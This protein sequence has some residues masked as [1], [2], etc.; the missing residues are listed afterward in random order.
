MLNTQKIRTDFPILNQTDKPLV[1]FDNA[2]MT[3]RPIQVIEEI[4]KY[5]TEYPAC[6]GRS[7]HKL[8]L[9]VGRKITEGRQKV[10]KFINAKS[11]KEIIFTKNTT[12][13][14]NLVAN[15]I[16]LKTG[17][18]VLGSH[19]EHNS[20]LLPWLLA[21][22]RKGIIY[23]KIEPDAN[24]FFSFENYKRELESGQVK[25]VSMVYVSNLDGTMFPVKEIIELAHQY[26]ALVLIDAAQAAPHQPID[27]VQLDADFLAFSGHKLLGPSGTGVLYGKQSLL[28]N[29]AP[30]II[31]GGTV[32]NSTYENFT[33]DNVPERFEAGL[34]HYSGIMGM[35][36]AI[37]YLTEIGLSN[38]KEHEIMLNKYIT[39]E[40][41]GLPKLHLLG[42]ADPKARGGIF[43]FYIDNLDSQQ[44][45]VMLDSMANIAVR[46]GQHCVHSWFNANNIKNSVRASLYLY[47]TLEEAK[48]FVE[49]V[50]KIIQLA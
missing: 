9:T 40:L 13:S 28:E 14:I 38:I 36:Q 50:K 42:P 20:N 34:Q 11:E 29:L 25:L 30:F 35:A 15:S 49:T 4:N 27:V 33:L 19:K 2:C 47:N 6:G 22:Q 23:K 5:Y 17:D 41:S 45:A 31:G 12:E 1:Y 8:A 21:A 3:L 26:G 43:S 44:N 48:L 7:G 10:A 37:D 39:D 46:A 18:I 24:D 32:I 16:D